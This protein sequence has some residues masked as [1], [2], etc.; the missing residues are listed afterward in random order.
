MDWDTLSWVL[1]IALIVVGAPIVVGPVL[2]RFSVKQNANP[3]LDPVDPREEQFPSDVHDHFLDAIEGM[4]EMGFQIAA[5]FAQTGQVPN[6]T[7]YL[8]VLQNRVQKDHAVAV[9]MLVTQAG[10][11]TIRTAY[12]CFCCRFEDG[13]SMNTGNCGELIVH[14]PIPTRR[15][16]AFPEIRDLSRLY[17][18]HQ[19]L[20]GRAGGAKRALPARESL[21]SVIAEDMVK[22]LRE[23][24]GLGYYWLDEAAGCFRPTWKGACIMTWKLVWPVSSVRRF[25]R[26]RRNAALLDELGL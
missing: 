15:Q 10:A 16:T 7:T 23:Q 14:A 25:L 26:G 24:Q 4:D 20:C 19:A 6:L 11:R 9:A 13:S 18:I 17:R 12:A 3:V 1:L 22:E 5:Y 8:A 21:A 2:V